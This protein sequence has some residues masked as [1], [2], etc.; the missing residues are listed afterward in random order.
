MALNLNDKKAIVAEMS[1]VVTNSVSAI[2]A[3]YR[4]ST[5]SQMTELR[6]KARDMGVKVHVLRNTLARRA[7]T[8]TAYDCLKDALTGPIVLLFS[9]DEPGAAAKLLRDFVKN[10]AN[11]EVRG[12]AM[13]GQL[14]GPE[15]LEAVAS[16]PSKDEAIAMLM[17]VM[18]GPVTKLVRTLA[19]PY[20]MAT[21]V[22]GAVSA[23][24]QA[25]AA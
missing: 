16:L 14:L 22:M 17:S 18:N 12:I 2:A 15:K 10:N 8:E 24:K 7:V 19:E 13:N 6:V 3:D 5:V 23:K 11:F 20:A 4:G 9:Q 1:E 21:R 25:E